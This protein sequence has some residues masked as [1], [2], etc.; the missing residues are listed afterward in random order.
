MSALD[1]QIGGKHYKSM[2]YQPMQLA[3]V[4]GGSPNFLNVTKYLT[5]DKGSK[6]KN[7]Q[8]ALHSVELEEELAEIRVANYMTYYPDYEGPDIR[9]FS[10][11]F[12]N[13]IVI[14]RTLYCLLVGHLQ[15]SKDIIEGLIAEAKQDAKRFIET[16]NEE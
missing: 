15:E 16:S 4:V 9:E 10:Q 5:R 6:V 12:N 11:Q 3:Y 13:P 1:K 7:L 2:A 14:E 8:K